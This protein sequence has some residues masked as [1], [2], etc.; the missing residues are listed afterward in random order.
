MSQWLRSQKLGA[1]PVILS[2][3]PVSICWQNLV[4]QGKLKSWITCVYK[5][6][7]PRITK[8][9]TL[10]SWYNF[11]LLLGSHWKKRLVW[12]S[13]GRKWR[14]LSKEKQE[15]SFCLLPSQRQV[16][17]P[18]KLSFKPGLRSTCSAL[19]MVSSPLDIGKDPR[20]QIWSL[21]IDFATWWLGF[22]PWSFNWSE[23]WNPLYNKIILIFSPFLGLTWG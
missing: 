21:K 16:W 8:E 17:T 4:L 5:F 12:K 18:K 23:A 19:S 15:G 3:T 7:G 14:S 9:L 22:L 11:T 2:H 10:S 13:P 1:Y 20:L 6:A